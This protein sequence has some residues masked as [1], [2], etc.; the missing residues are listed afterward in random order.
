[1]QLRLARV[2]RRG[3]TMPLELVAPFVSRCEQYLFLVIVGNGI[4][5][6]SRV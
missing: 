2:G 4:D 6:A 3:D 1:M 5:I